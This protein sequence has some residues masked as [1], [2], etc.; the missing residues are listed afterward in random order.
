VFACASVFSQTNG[1]K[2]ILDD[3]TGSYFQEDVPTVRS[4]YTKASKFRE[5]AILLKFDNRQTQIYTKDFKLD[6]GQK[7][8]ESFFSFNNRLFILASEFSTSNLAYLIYVAEIDK[9]NGEVKHYWKQIFSLDKEYGRQVIKFGL[10]KNADPASLFITLLVQNKGNN[11]VLIQEF[12]S[13]FKT[14]AKLIT[15]NNELTPQAHLIE[16]LSITQEGNI[17]LL[18][19]LFYGNLKKHVNQAV[20]T[21]SK[22]VLRIFNK[23]GSLKGESTIE[24]PGHWIRLCKVFSNH[25][26]EL[27]LASYYS[28]DK[29]GP[30][31]S[32]SI[33]QINSSTGSLSL[34]SEKELNY[35]AKLDS[36]IS[37][38]S[39][40][41]NPENR[42][43][44]LKFCSINST[45][46]NGTL[47]ITENFNKYFLTKSNFARRE[48]GTGGNWSH[49]NY[50]VYK[51]GELLICKIDSNNN[52]SWS[53]VLPKYQ[54]QEIPG[55]DG[56]S[57]PN[58]FYK[59]FFDTDTRSFFDGFTS[60]LQGNNLTVSF[61]DAIEKVANRGNFGVSKPSVI[62]RGKD[63]KF[64]HLDLVS[65]Q[66][67]QVQ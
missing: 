5:Y 66:F 54:R 27:L 32:V 7:K 36:P 42:P 50:T 6:L 30:A 26:N 8:F 28:S 20:L 64:I 44:L 13:N 14:N 21:E 37:I 53:K 34:V 39:S 4:F 24:K 65:G 57:G 67:H 59:S 60:F 48:D 9:L 56:A 15:I 23:Y 45:I 35:T 40:R 51:F 1:F 52:L 31:S 18:Y 17:L 63:R 3:S 19:H 46:D 16:D 29:T 61:I 25:K 41:E 58:F 49:K 33:S 22:Y 38:K 2:K 10:V 62:Y 12:D 55:Y 47:L 43:V 11:K